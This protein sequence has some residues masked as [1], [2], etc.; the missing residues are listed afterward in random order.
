MFGLKRDY[1]SPA[2]LNRVLQ[3]MH[4]HQPVT[5]T[6]LGKRARVSGLYTPRANPTTRK[7]QAWAARVAGEL[8]EIGLV[9]RT[10]HHVGYRHELR[11]SLTSRGLSHLELTRAN[12]AQ[13]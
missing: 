5:G 8:L 13:G 1:H 9:K 12:P 3:L 6:E 11:Y 10:Y 2:T 4:A 7:D